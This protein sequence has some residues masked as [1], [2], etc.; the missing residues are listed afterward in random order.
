M[1]VSLMARARRAWKVCRCLSAVDLSLSTHA[2][3]ARSRC[4]SLTSLHIC[5]DSGCFWST[6]AS[7]CLSYDVLVD[8]SHMREEDECSSSE[9]CGLTFSSVDF[10]SFHDR[11]GP[12]VP[13][14]LSST[15][16]SHMWVPFIRPVHA[17]QQPLHLA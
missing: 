7:V 5:E 16:T 9:H 1:V 14:V 17:A 4:P 2:D 3:P 10:N 11:L 6:K 15:H 13:S 8:C 12:F